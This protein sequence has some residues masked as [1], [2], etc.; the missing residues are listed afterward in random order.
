[1]DHRLPRSRSQSWT[2]SRTT[3][4]GNA[5]FRPRYG[6]IIV[7]TLLLFPV[8]LTLCRGYLMFFAAKDTVE[9]WSERWRRRI[10]ERGRK[11]ERRRIKQELE[12]RGAP[13]T[14][15][16]AEILDGKSDDD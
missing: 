6:I 7:G 3:T 2:A 16:L 9:W 11:E 1:M 14:P 15:E 5:R 4:R 12:R 8:A 13:L 10:F